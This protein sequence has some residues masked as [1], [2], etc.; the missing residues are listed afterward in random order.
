MSW[1]DGTF[2]EVDI[3]GRR[4]EVGRAPRGKLDGLVRTEGAY[5]ATSWEGRC[6]YRFATSGGIETLPGR[7]EQPA[8]LGYD[9]VRQ[10]LVVPLFGSDA[11]ESLPI[12][13][14]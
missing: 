14:R 11:I 1:R 8:D 10:R 13:P 6:V 3:E 9:A 4:T 2:Y 5:Y 7:L 12:A